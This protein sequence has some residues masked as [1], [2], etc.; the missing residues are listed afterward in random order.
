MI[1]IVKPRMLLR[2][3]RIAILVIFA[4]SAVLT[5]PDVVSQVMMAGPVIVLYISSVLVAM[6]VTRRKRKED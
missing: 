4:L 1:G 5:P 6:I 2:T 3:W